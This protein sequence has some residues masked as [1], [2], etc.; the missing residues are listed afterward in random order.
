[1][2]LT[3]G[4][5][6]IPEIN[7]NLRLTSNTF[8][9]VIYMDIIIDITTDRSLVAAHLR[10]APEVKSRLKKLPVQL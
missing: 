10:S 2:R 4:T 7:F 3:I 9:S 5:R 1:M 8:I 6:F